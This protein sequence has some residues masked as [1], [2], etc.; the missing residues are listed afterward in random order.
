MNTDE[1]Q[2]FEAKWSE[3]RKELIDRGI[4]VQPESNYPRHLTFDQIRLVDELCYNFL[5][6]LT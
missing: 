5:F 6:L 1:F 3:T 4:F 2:I